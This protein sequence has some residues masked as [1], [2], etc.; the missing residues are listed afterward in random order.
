MEW[1]KKLLPLMSRMLIGLTIFFFIASFFQLFYLHKKIENS[2]KIESS[3]SILTNGANASEIKEEHYIQLVQWTTLATLEEKTL[4]QRYHQANVLLMARIWVRYLSF[5][6]GMI[7][8]LVGASFILGKIE[9]ASSTID[10]KTPQLD[11]S[12][13]TSSPGIILAAFGTILMLT[14]VL[15]HNEIKV[16]DGPAYLHLKFLSVHGADKPETLKFI[17]EHDNEEVSDIP[18]ASEE[19]IDIK[20]KEYDELMKNLNN[21]LNK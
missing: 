20:K 15:V 2:P 10:S 1:Q 13:K 3:E 21:E 8:C 5:V 17:T 7:L 14:S 6:T 12:L 11:F 4:Q 18:H 16:T 19:I 9:I